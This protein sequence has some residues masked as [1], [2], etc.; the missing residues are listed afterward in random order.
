VPVT[1]PPSSSTVADRRRVEIDGG[2]R[3]AHLGGDPRE[4]E[5][6]ERARA[7][8]ERAVVRRVRFGELE[9]ALAHHVLEAEIA[10]RHAGA[11]RDR[12]RSVPAR[13]PRVD[14]DVLERHRAA[15]RGLAVADRAVPQAERAQLE[16]GAS[17]RTRRVL[18]GRGLSVA[19][20][21]RVGVEMPGTVANQ[22]HDRPLDDDFIHHHASL[23]ERQ[24]AQPHRETVGGEE[25]LVAAE[26]RV[27]RDRDVVERD[28]DAAAQAEPDRTCLDLAPEPAAEAGEQSVGVP[29]RDDRG[30]D[31]GRDPDQDDAHDDERD[32]APAGHPGSSW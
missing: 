5:R 29:R 13:L 19:S 27:I 25:R 7:R 32:P 17:A 20:A 4:R 23:Q 21:E 12:D 28:A 8:R 16:R 26:C 18:R 15:G 11:Y 30:D 2:R 1:L 24:H 31:D 10:T 6:A 14:G 9:D 22:V 3:R